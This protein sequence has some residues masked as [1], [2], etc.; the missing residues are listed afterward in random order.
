MN[1]YIGIIYKATCIINGK[2]YIGQTIKTLEERRREHIKRVGLGSKF[3]F[4]NALRKYGENNFI[5]E[6]IDSANSPD[7]LNIK[8]CDLINEY[9]AFDKSFGYNMTYGGDGVKNPSEE[10]R[11]RM[12][13][14]HIGNKNWLGKHH[15]EETKA[16]LSKIHTGKKQSEEHRIKNIIGHIGKKQSEETKE[17]IRQYFKGRP[18]SPETVRKISES[19]KGKI[20][21][22]ETRRKISLAQIGRPAW[23]KGI[24]MSQETKNKLR[25]TSEGNKNATGHIVSNELKNKLRLIYTGR[26]LSPETIEKMKEAQRKR[27]Q[28]E[29]HIYKQEEAV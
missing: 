14:V 27:R 12:G 15:T 11:K 28:S 3:Y 17:K 13:E 4:H 7:E 18:R 16:L 20:I 5:W 2:V 1:E 19:N 29:L 22:E 10:V 23:N 8:E 9:Q 25:K 26:K 21:S 24:P 6:T